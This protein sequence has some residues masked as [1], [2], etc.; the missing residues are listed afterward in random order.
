MRLFYPIFIFLFFGYIQSKAQ[1]CLP[2]STLFSTQQQIDDLPTNYPGCT[3]I[4]GNII[5]QGADITNLGGFSALT[6]IGGSITISNNPLLLNLNGLANMDSIIGNFYIQ[7]NDALIDLQNL[8][9]LDYIGGTL[10]VHGHENMTCFNG[11][12]TL[13]Y[14][15]GSLI[16]SNNLVMTCFQGLI[17]LDTIG[18]SLTID[19]NQSMTM[20]NGLANL[21]LVGGNFNIFNNLILTNMSGLNSL[22]KIEGNLHFFNNQSLVTLAGINTLNTINGNLIIDRNQVLTSLSGLTGLTNLNGYLTVHLNESLPNLCGLENIDPELLDSIH[23]DNNEVLAICNVQSVCD[24]LADAQNPAV[25]VNN[26][27]GCATRQEIL[28]E[29]DMPFDCTLLPIELIRFS[30]YFTPSGNVLEWSTASEIN[31][32]VFE[33]ERSEDMKVFYPIASVKGAGNSTEILQYA[34]VDKTPLKNIS[35][36]RLKQ[37]DFDGKFSYS[38]I[39]KIVGMPGNSPIKVNP[40]PGTDHIYLSIGNKN[41][42]VEIYNAYGVLQETFSEVPDFINVTSYKNGIY[43]INV[44]GV[45]TKFVVQHD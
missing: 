2:G 43:F 19:N 30:G 5:V 7:H 17:H 1:S 26:V 11:L 29:C 31:N 10:E 13:D 23:I 3:R 12:S 35:F 38:E 37:V 14:I 16:V 21:K 42:V 44:G 22:N 20:L 18:G 25:V 15:G 39:I 33:I 34:W 6:Y 32:D 28:D 9:N 8:S 4:S 40:N 24:F 45:L 36:Y 41:Q 27:P